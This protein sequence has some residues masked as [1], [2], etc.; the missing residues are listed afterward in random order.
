[1]GQGIPPTLTIFIGPRFEPI[2]LPTSPYVLRH[3]RRL[4]L[5]IEWNLLYLFVEDVIVYVIEREY[6]FYLEVVEHHHFYNV[7]K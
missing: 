4:N 3:S 1:M 6:D 7:H 5:F 2:T